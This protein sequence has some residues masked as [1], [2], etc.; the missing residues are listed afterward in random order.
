[1]RS[2][3]YLAFIGLLN[4]VAYAKKPSA[5]TAQ[6]NLTTVENAQD[7]HEQTTDPDDVQTKKILSTFL[8]MI[9][10]FACIVADP[11]NPHN[12]GAQLTQLFAGIVAIAVEVTHK[13]NI[14]LHIDPIDLSLDLSQEEIETLKL[15]LIE[16]LSR[17]QSTAS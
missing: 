5:S 9:S 14:P 11:H 6:I 16:I 13:K 10:N 1:M 12:V 7:L 17:L 3:R 15:Q 8:G 4:G 2:L